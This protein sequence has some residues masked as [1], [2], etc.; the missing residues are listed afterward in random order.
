[1][2]HK[3]ETTPILVNRRIP[4]QIVLGPY[5][6]ML[7]TQ[8]NPLLIHST[9]IYFHIDIVITSILIKQGGNRL[10]TLHTKAVITAVLTNGL[11]CN[12]DSRLAPARDPPVLTL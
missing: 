7:T 5:N 9:D 2:S 1:M 6:G 3:I 11:I 4:R 10:H 12:L 8:W